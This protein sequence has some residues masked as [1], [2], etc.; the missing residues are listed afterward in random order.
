MDGCVRAFAPLV[1][2]GGREGTSGPHRAQ[3]LLQ[4]TGDYF[5]PMVDTLQA[6]CVFG[7]PGRQVIY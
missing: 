6:L 3:E 4:L 2:A 1:V 7:A 5:L